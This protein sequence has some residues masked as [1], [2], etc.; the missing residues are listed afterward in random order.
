LIR[1]SFD[2]QTYQPQ[3]Q[4]DWQAAYQRFKSIIAS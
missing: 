1:R 2:F 4:E 3:Q